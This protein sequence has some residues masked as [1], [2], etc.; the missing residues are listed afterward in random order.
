[1]TNEMRCTFYTA[2]RMIHR[3]QDVD[4]LWNINLSIYNLH[5]NVQYSS[6]LNRLTRKYSLYYT[7][8]LIM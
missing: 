7:I 3:S 8:F 6:H 5:E 4:I 1:M 2:R